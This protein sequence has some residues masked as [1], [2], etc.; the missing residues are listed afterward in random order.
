MLKKKSYLYSISVGAF[1]NNVKARK[2]MTFEFRKLEKCH[3]LSPTIFL[4]TYF[5]MALY[6]RAMGTIRSVMYTIC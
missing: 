4:A 1:Q 5:Y 6:N 2:Q 3:F